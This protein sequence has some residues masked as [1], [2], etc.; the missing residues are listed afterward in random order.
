[1][2]PVASKEKTMCDKEK[3]QK[4]E[5]KWRKKNPQLSRHPKDMCIVVLCLEIRKSIQ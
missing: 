3:M 2:N 4:W 5:K 1:M